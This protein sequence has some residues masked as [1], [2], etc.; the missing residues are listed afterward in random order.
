MFYMREQIKLFYNLPYNEQIEMLIE[1]LAIHI[2]DIRELHE[3]CKEL[4]KFKK[5]YDSKF[6]IQNYFNC[7]R[8]EKYEYLRHDDIL[9]NIL[10][11]NGDITQFKNYKKLE[12]A[13]KKIENE[14]PK[15]QK[16]TF[17]S[18][19]EF[20]KYAKENNIIFQ[21]NVISLSYDGKINKWILIF[22]K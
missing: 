3:Y 19:Q 14:I 9:K 10:A 11:F 20:I 22:E 16:M 4:A 21:K 13:I 5:Q 12:N 6:T 1:E 18:Y 7:I 2:E 15:R 8:N 17:K